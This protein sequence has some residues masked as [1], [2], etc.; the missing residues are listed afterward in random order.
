MNVRYFT[1]PEGKEMAV[2]PKVEFDAMTELVQHTTAVSDYRA[3]KLP[4]LTPDETRAFVDAA[5]PLA[6]WRRYRGL[7][8]TALSREA[9]VTQN[10][11]SELENGKR[12]GSVEVWLRLARAL[13][14]PVEHVVDAD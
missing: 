6:F 13:D 14:L 5:S 12:T 9:G 4:G 7:T 8:Q 3:G 2:L 11:L 10:Y 1:T